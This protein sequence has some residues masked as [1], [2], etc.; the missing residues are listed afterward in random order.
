M[1]QLLRLL[2]I[3]RSRIQRGILLRHQR[4][5]CI[6][7]FRALLRVLRCSFGVVALRFRFLGIALLILLFLLLFGGCVVALRGGSSNLLRLLCAL[8]LLANLLL[9]LVVLLVVVDEIDGLFGLR[10]LS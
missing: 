4:G 10:Q 1:H 7:L 2:L 9:L 3:P 6:L 5:R 8:A